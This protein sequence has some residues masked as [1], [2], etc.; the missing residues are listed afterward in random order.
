MWD[1]LKPGEAFFLTDMELALLLEAKGISS[2]QGFPLKHYPKNEEEVLQTIFSMTEKGLLHA[3]EE[4]FQTAGELSACMEILKNAKGI[5]ALIPEEK[6]IPQICCYPGE[7]VLIIEPSA[8]R[9]STFKLQRISWEELEEKL[10]ESGP[11]MELQF[12]NKGD[13]APVW[14]AVLRNRENGLVR[15]CGEGEED[16]SIEI[17][18]KEIWQ[19]EE[20]L[21]L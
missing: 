12:C 5:L 15:E 10:R 7:N 3:R 18:R 19:T 16:F 14:Q 9:N 2:F 17:F 11:R 1:R 13:E 6:D 20:V 21:L 4:E 8:L